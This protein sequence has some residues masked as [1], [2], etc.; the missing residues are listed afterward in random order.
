M[1][2]DTLR[3]ASDATRGG[4]DQM[5]P[6]TITGASA[7]GYAEHECDGSSYNKYGNRID[8]SQ[9]AAHSFK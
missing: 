6:G 5:K 3:L 9:L 2:K 8:Y 7:K 1:A 4:L